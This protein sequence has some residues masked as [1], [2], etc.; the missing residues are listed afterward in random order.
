MPCV[1]G[2]VHGCL[3]GVGFL[4]R[5]LVTSF[6]TSENGTRNQNK[7]EPSRLSLYSIVTERGKRG[8]KY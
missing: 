6:A 3:G 5:C 1:F 7:A 8:L 2:G 4:G